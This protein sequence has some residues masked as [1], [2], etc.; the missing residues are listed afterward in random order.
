MGIV[1]LRKEK[2]LSLLH[3]GCG[4]G[5]LPDWISGFDEVRLDIENTCSPD[6][7]ANMTNM[8]EIGQYDAIFCQHALEHLAPH[9]VPVALSEFLR[10]LSP[11]GSAMITVPD[12]E[13]VRPTDEVILESP[14][15]PITGLDMIYGYRKA[16][17]EHPYMAHRTGFIKD[18]LH[19][20]ML[21]AGFS[22]VKT[23]R[24]GNYNLMT[25]G[26]K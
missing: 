8:G 3:V 15:G 21:D 13:D 18:T 7:V 20:A 6:I 23:D 11:G 2:P 10:V 25:V 26:K 22:K 19:K 1:A 9:D 17:K 4:S 12:L 5:Y 16:L 24:L 14:A